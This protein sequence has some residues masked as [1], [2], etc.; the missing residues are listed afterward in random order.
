MKF[1]TTFMVKREIS[2]DDF[3]RAV[4]V[5]LGSNYDTPTNVCNAKFGEVRETIKEVIVCSAHVESDYTASIGYDRQEEYWDKEKKVDYVNGNRREYL[6]DVKKTRIVTDWQ[7]HS[8]H[9]GGDATCCAFNEGD[10][11]FAIDEH[12]RLVTVIKAIDTKNIVEK[13]EADVSYG[14]LETAKRNCEFFV[15]MGIHYPGDHHKDERSNATV[16]V[17]KLS[18]YKLPYYIVEFEFDGQS[19]TAEGFACGDVAVETELPPNNV[20]IQEILDS[21]SKPYKKKIKTGWILFGVSIVLASVVSGFA[22]FSVWLNLFWILVPA[23]LV[24]AIIA[25]T[26]GNKFYNARQKEL[27]SDNKKTKLNNLKA[28]LS[29][30]GYEE[31]SEEEEKLFEF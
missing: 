28:A 12:D 31:L 1:E 25:T 14:G 27:K 30:R 29:A 2:K 9:I 15:E 4:L 11:R 10:D 8:G 16:E 7:P 5:K 3:L 21:E 26:K 24:F 6:V 18:C 19:Y 20:N 23:F 22:Y 17:T 13:G